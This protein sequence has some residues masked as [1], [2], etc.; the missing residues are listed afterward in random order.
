[1]HPFGRLA[2]ALAVVAAG[3]WLAAASAAGA[4]EPGASPGEATEEGRGF[5]G[6]YAF[7]DVHVVPMDRRRVLE[8]RTVV[9]RDGTI[10]TVGPAGTVEVPADAVR[11]E[12]RGRYLLPGLGD[13]HVELP[14]PDAAEGE[15]EDLLFLYVAHGVTAVRQGT[16]RRGH[17]SLKNRLLRDRL[18]GPTLYVTSPPLRTGTGSAPDS[19]GSEL[20][21]AAVERVAGERWDLLRI[22]EEMSLRDWEWMTEAVVRFGLP[23]GGPVP[24]SVGLRRALASGISTVDRLDGWLEAVVD[25]RY[26]RRIEAAFAPRD[27]SGDTADGGPRDAGPAELGRRPPP[28][29]LDSL[30]RAVQPRKIWAVAGRARAAGTWTVPALHA[31][32]VR[33]PAL[34]LD[35]LL[36]LPELRWTSPD[37]RERWA[38]RRSGPPE[39]DSATAR[40]LGRSRLAAVK[41]LN[42]LNAGLVAGTASPGPFNVPGASLHRELRLM[43]TAGL[44]PYEVLVAATRNVARYASSQLGESGRFGTVAEG[45]RADLLLVEGNPLDDLSALERRAGVM[46]RGRWLPDD[47]IR[48]RLAAIAERRG[49]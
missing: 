18:L 5:P 26:E 29:P 33:N 47:E 17:R 40:L 21:R 43:E 4:P 11:I 31:S 32:E 12:G 36:A 42:D 34:S 10:R 14:A 7:V 37:A 44:L 22:P 15:L 45:N 35:S 6:A 1:M 49:G 38:A 48:E 28:P 13:M 30:V 19:V 39:V 20:V 25:D 9:V 27:P 16:G 46:V 8:N 24:D 23:F 3:G 41:A 2:G